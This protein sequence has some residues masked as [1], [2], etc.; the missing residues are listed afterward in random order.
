MYPCTRCGCCCKNVGLLIET[1]GI[2]FPY[3]I[4][5]DGSCSKLSEKNECTVYDERPLICN[6]DKFIEATGVDKDEFYKANI[7]V[8]N[9]MM[10]A[11]GIDESLR[12]KI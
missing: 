10:D 9:S 5:E 11:A 2:E 4:N 8:C 12:I 6:F 3:D 1:T 7:M